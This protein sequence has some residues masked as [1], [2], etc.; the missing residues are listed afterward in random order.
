VGDAFA[1]HAADLLVGGLAAHAFAHGGV[2]LCQFGQPLGI[3]GDD[4]AA[5][6]GRVR[7]AG[8]VSGLLEPVEQLGDGSGGQAQLLGQLARGCRAGWP[9]RG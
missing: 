1:A 6:I 7:R 3:G 5:A 9:W 4:G 8:D 2:L